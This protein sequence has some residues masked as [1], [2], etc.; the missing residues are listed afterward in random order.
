MTAYSQPLD[1]AINKIFKENIQFLLEKDRL[2]FDNI[3]PKIKLNSLRV[4][5]F[6]YINNVWNDDSLIT[7]NIIINGLKKSGTV[8]NN[9]LSLE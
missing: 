8:G 5:L 6:R 3:N 1:V 7:K 4:N 2:F 9:Y